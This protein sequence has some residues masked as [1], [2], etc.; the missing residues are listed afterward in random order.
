MNNK[1]LVISI[2]AGVSLLGGSLFAYSEFTTFGYDNNAN[3][4]ESSF[5]GGHVTLAVYDQFGNMKSY[6]QFDNAIVN[7]GENCIAEY[8]FGVAHATCTL[9][10]TPDF[11]T[12]ALGTGVP[13]VAGSFGTAT[14]QTPDT[15]KVG[16]AAITQTSTGASE[17]AA[18]SSSITT[19][20]AT[21]SPAATV[22]YRDVGL[23][24]ASALDLLAY[25]GLGDATINGGADSLTV[26][27]TITIGP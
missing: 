25:Q 6:R 24:N 8:L 19:I 13:I 5:I 15:E 2:I 21:F 16:T 7:D 14:I 20:I 12:I 17:A 10:A 22:T 18:A 23:G 11:L 1:H 26:T 4:M 3:I 9:G 27:W